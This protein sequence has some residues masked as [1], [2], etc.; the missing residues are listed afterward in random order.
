[1]SPQASASE[2]RLLTPS[3]DR[4][5]PRPDGWLGLAVPVALVAV[6]AAVTASGVVSPRILPSP[7]AVATA[8]YAL[9]FGDATTTLPGVV[10]FEGAGVFHI[11]ASLRRLLLAFALAAAVGVPLG[12]A[13]GLSR[14]VALVLDPLVQALRPIPIFAWLPLG[15]A[16]FGLG[17]GAARFL[18]FIGSVFP[19]VVS[20]ADGVMRVPKAW[21][22]TA[23]ML[24]TPR[25]QLPRKIY[26]PATLPS[27]V[28]GLRLGLTLGWMSVIVG[29][30]TG[31]SR[32]LGAMMMAA[33]EVGRLDRVIVGM[34]FFALLGLG[35]DLL[36]R[37]VSRRFTRWA[38]S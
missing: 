10:R 30:L 16:W 15:L 2:Q 24:G 20:T 25:S 19:I 3:R 22:E 1:M 13:L 31:T 26:L 14:R 29:E 37:R 5:K 34:A 6:W 21:A 12:L 38:S 18:I 8:A 35:T 33:R 23:L 7:A 11:A 4:V 28:T 17:E 9:L 32:G 27:I 36:V